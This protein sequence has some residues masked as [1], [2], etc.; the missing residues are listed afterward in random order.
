[1][2]SVSGMWVKIFQSVLELINVNV[3]TRGS[4]VWINW[5]VLIYSQFGFAG[6]YQMM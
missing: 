6:T 5:T 2:L 4:F 1:M 3:E